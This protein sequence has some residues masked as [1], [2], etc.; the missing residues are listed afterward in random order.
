MTQLTTRQNQRFESCLFLAPI[1]LLVSAIITVEWG[2]A[3]LA[4]ARVVYAAEGGRWLLKDH[5]LTQTVIHES[6]LRFSVAL[7]LLVWVLAVAS[8][9]F[10]RWRV[11]RAPLIYLAFVLPLSPI[12]VTVLKSS[13]PVSCPWDLEFFSGATP[14]QGGWWGA[15]TGQGGA[16][17]SGCFPAGHASGGYTFVALYFALRNSLPRWRFAGLAFGLLL[18]L[19]YDVAQQLRGAHFLSHGLWTL[20]ISWLFAVVGYWVWQLFASQSATTSHVAARP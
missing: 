10:P 13:L 6:G 17:E 11:A 12:V 9:L 5:W 20:A 19:T 16:Q 1:L 2:G 4:L 8:V 14:W 7:L 15:V 3:D 18:G